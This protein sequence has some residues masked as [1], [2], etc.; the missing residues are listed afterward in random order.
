MFITVSEVAK[1]LAMSQ[2]AVRRHCLRGDIPCICIGR[3]I[4]IKADFLRALEGAK[5][6]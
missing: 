1:R 2:S 5:S 3:S 6:E 4:R